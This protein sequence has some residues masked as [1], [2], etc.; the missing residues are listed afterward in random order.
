M[1]SI[2]TLSYFKD[3]YNYNYNLCLKQNSWEEFIMLSSLISRIGKAIELKETAKK[4]KR[5]RKRK[6]SESLDSESSESSE[7][8]REIKRLKKMEKQLKRKYQEMLYG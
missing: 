2:I 5:N 8:E 7:E 4:R 1:S 6:R 3:D